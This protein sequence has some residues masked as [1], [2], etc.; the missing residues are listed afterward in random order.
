M[1][2]RLVD[3]SDEINIQDIAYVSIPD[4]LRMAE[5]SSS[6]D[7]K[8]WSIKKGIAA[9]LAGKDGLQQVKKSMNITWHEIF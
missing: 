3:L 5:I 7:K 9:G 2:T 6:K 8:Y 1:K 4:F